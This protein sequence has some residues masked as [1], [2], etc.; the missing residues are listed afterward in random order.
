MN[1]FVGTTEYLAPEVL[2]QR[3]YGKEVDWWSLGVLIFEM[4]T[5]CPPFY[6]KNRQ[7]TFRMILSAELNIPDWLSPSSKGLIKE[8]L[9]RNP[10][11]RLG[12]GARGAAD[13]KRHA[14]FD[15]I[16]FPALYRKEVDPP[17]KPPPLAHDDTSHFDSR[18]TAKPAEDSPTQSP[19]EP[20]AFDGFSYQSPTFRGR[21]GD[22]AASMG[23]AAGSYS[24]KTGSLSQSQRSLAFGGSGGSSSVK[25]KS[26]LPRINS[27]EDLKHEIGTTF[28]HDGPVMVPKP[29]AE[30]KETGTD[31]SEDG[32]DSAEEEGY[33][34]LGQ[35]LIQSSL[36]DHS[37]RW[38]EHDSQARKK[39]DLT[40][41]SPDSA[42]HT[43][44]EAE[45]VEKEEAKEETG[46]ATQFGL[47][48]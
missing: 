42:G 21:L 8:L 28:A 4:I 13:I 37:P 23:S 11:Q 1:T 41:D 45:K 20:T 30:G 39:G 35:S 25:M 18:F 48:E 16:D 24:Q 29:V 38:R 17:Y 9:V 36:A 3:G 14:F 6:S 12:V 7:M 10:A 22:M 33:E 32:L 44:E 19:E 5:G 34:K 31:E 40:S 26:S 46:D 27:G 43:D 2:K 15:A 47:D